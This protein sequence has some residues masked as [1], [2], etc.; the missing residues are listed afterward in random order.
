[1]KHRLFMS[2]LD[3]SVCAGSKVVRPGIGSKLSSSVTLLLVLCFLLIGASPAFADLPYPYSNG[4]E[5]ATDQSHWELS[6]FWS[7]S[8]DTV[9]RVSHSGLY[10]LDNNPSELD[11]SQQSTGQE[12]KLLDVVAIPSDAIRP[13]L[14]YLYLSLIHI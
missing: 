12:A 3:K 10:H 11:Q 6:G 2:T 5:S 13:V 4:F 8:N 7:I 9:D 14:T 1:M